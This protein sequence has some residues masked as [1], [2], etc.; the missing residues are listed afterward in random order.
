M[1][2]ISASEIWSF[3]QRYL[4]FDDPADWWNRLLELLARHSGKNVKNLA[5]LELAEQIILLR[6]NYGCD[7]PEGKIPTANA[8]LT[9]EMSKRWRQQA[10]EVWMLKFGEKGS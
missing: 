6:E 10:L 3:A 7:D 1:R 4:T 8:L 9:L 5:G 2:H